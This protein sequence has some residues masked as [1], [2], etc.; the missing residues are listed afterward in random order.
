MY[1]HQLCAAETKTELQRNK[2]RTIRKIEGDGTGG[3]SSKIQ[4]VI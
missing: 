3:I 2:R 4:D 1:A